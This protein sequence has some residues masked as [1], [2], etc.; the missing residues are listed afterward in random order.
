MTGW[1]RTATGST[2]I[3][4][5]RN[6]QPGPAPAL[7]RPQIAQGKAWGVLGMGFGGRKIRAACRRRAG[8]HR[9]HRRRVRRP[10]LPVAG[11]VP[12]RAGDGSILGSVGIS[13]DV[14][15][16][17]AARAVYSVNSGLVADT[18]EPA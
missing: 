18:G 17:D 11:G 14:L 5:D 3:E 13:G 12:I 1:P 9:R 8:L 6:L 16:Q 10:I 15:E 7:L 2:F 4:V